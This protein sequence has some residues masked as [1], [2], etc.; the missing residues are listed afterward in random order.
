MNKLKAEFEERFVI[1][2]GLYFTNKG[3]RK[4]FIFQVQ[5]TP[6]DIWNW[7]QQQ[8]KEQRNGIADM[9]KMNL[10][11]RNEHGVIKMIRDFLLASEE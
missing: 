10:G 1:Q 7:I 11:I 8:L 3:T 6:K 2:D 4:R 9:V 5:V